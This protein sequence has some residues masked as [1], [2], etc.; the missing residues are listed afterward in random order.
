M[1]TQ[2][3]ANALS[4][5]LKTVMKTNESNTDKAK[6]S[7]QMCTQKSKRNIFETSIIIAEEKVHRQLK[8]AVLKTILANRKYTEPG[9]DQESYK[10]IKAIT[11]RNA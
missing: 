1:C 5:N 11:I 4:E 2:E 8:P 9:H 3:T 6:D 7:E 10:K